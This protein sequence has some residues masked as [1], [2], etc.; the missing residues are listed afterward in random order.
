MDWIIDIAKVV[1]KADPKVMRNSRANVWARRAIYGLNLN[2]ETAT[3]LGAYFGQNH[4]TVLHAQKQHKDAIDWDRE[5][6][7]LFIEFSNTVFAY[8][9]LE[10]AS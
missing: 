8:Q 3:A 6:R 1:F 7:A 2:D 9:S 5:Y 10:E 4:S